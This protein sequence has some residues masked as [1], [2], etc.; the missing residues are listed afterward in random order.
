VSLIA[1]VAAATAQAG[2]P[3]AL[4]VTLQV[5]PESAALRWSDV[6]GALDGESAWA[7]RS[8]LVGPA[9][10]LAV[11]QTAGAEQEC[12]EAVRFR[13]LAAGRIE[14]RVQVASDLAG[15]LRWSIDYDD[16]QSITLRSCLPRPSDDRRACLRGGIPRPLLE[17]LQGVLE[18]RLQG[19]GD[20]VPVQAV[21]FGRFSECARSQ[22]ETHEAPDRP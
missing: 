19:S 7:L 10:W 6:G 2:G 14:Y 15:S 11:E 22:G 16:R 3:Q 13:V 1:V 9:T 20:F 17:P 21:R 18:A 5:G 8:D 12:A 4:P